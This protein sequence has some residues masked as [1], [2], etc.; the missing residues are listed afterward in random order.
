MAAD[1][2]LAAKK[3]LPFSRC[4]GVEEAQY[5]AVYLSD[6]EHDVDYNRTRLRF[7]D[8]AIWAIQHCASF[9]RYEIVDVSDVSVI[10]D[11]V[12]EY[13]FRDLQDVVLF[14]LKWK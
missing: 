13:Q 14:N 8:A 9:V 7:I 12:A 5:H 3:K 1:C 11:Q 2:I 10:H 6:S 4:A